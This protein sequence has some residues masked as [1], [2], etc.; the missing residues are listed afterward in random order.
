MVGTFGV[1]P[2]SIHTIPTQLMAMTI[3][4]SV[5]VGL[6]LSVR[7]GATISHNVQR[8]KHLMLGC[9]VFATVLVSFMTICL[10]VYRKPFILMF[11]SDPLVVHV[12]GYGALCAGPPTIYGYANFLS[13]LLWLLG[14]GCTEIVVA[15]LC[16]CL[17]SLLLLVFGSGPFGVG[18]GMEGWNHQYGNVVDLDDPRCDLLCRDSWWGVLRGM[19][20]PLATVHRHGRRL[21]VQGVCI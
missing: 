2:L 17:A 15:G 3:V 16:L 13:F 5:G 1:V 8:A 4:I 20:L 10:W 19:G 18:D 7:I 9:S 21:G 14:L 6:A 11:S 12:S